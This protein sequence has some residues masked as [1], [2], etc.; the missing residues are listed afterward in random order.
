VSLYPEVWKRSEQNTLNADTLV[1]HFL[2]AML[3]MTS[4]MLSG[5]FDH[6]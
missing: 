5:H 1:G 3:G 4:A 6:A 2:I